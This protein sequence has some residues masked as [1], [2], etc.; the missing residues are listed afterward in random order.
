VAFLICER[1][2]SVGE[3]PAA[4][5]TQALTEGARS[6]GFVPRLTVVEMTGT[7]AHCAASA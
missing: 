7:C 5:L 1:C 3:I 4:S 2:G 6:S